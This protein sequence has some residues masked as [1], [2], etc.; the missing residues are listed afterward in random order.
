MLLCAIKHRGVHDVMYMST[1]ASGDDQ[2]E[3]SVDAMDAEKPEA[4]VVDLTDVLETDAPLLDRSADAPTLPVKQ[5]V[6]DPVGGGC[7]N[8]HLIITLFI[9]VCWKQCSFMCSCACS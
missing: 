4:V 5:E 8:E 9:Y 3:T 2:S 1:S 6:T 7:E